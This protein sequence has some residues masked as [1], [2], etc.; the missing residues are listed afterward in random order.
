MEWYFT[1][2][3]IKEHG[4]VMTFL[5]LMVTLAIVMSPIYIPAIRRTWWSLKRKV[6][7]RKKTKE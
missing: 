6:L 7:K 1:I 3:S 4:W 2:Q 5:P